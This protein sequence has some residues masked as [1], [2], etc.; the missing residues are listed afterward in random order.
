[1]GTLER[2]SFLKKVSGLLGLLS[3]STFTFAKSKTMKQSPVYFYHVVYF[4][5]KD[6]NDE[7][8]KKTFVSHLKDLTSGISE[9]QSAFIG[10]P[11]PT[12]RPVIDNT[13]TFSIVLAFNSQKD[14]DVYQTH[15]VH[16]KFI[17]RAQNMWSKVQV[18]DSITVG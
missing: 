17:E 4:W 6:A 14:Q 9:I 18:Y 10:S 13:Y 8:V 11:A 1:M 3:L 5:L 12:D 2:R 7:A 15:P 16:L